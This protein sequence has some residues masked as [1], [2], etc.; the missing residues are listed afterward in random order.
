MKL[1]ST[2]TISFSCKDCKFFIHTL[3]CKWF[4][5]YKNEIPKDIPC[6]I[7][8]KGCKYIVPKDIK[9]HPLYREAI[10]L[11]NGKPIS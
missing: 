7:L 6:N 11:F 2:S 1:R 10:K 3:K 8:N 4:E 5:I 9:D